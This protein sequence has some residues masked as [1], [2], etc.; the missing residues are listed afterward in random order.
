MTVG[1]MCLTYALYYPATTV[2]TPC[3]STFPDKQFAAALVTAGA[4]GP[5]VVHGST[6]GVRD[7]ALRATNW[8]TFDAA[9]DSVVYNGNLVAAICLGDT[10]VPVGDTQTTLMSAVKPAVPYQAPVISCGNSAVSAS[11]TTTTTATTTTGGVS[12]TMTGATAASTAAAV[13][14]TIAAGSS[15]T[16]VNTANTV[17]GLIATLTVVASVA[18]LL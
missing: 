9:Y 2:L 18:V 7:V 11:T 3:I 6:D 10:G 14:A 17:N 16:N 13:S 8:S 1:E 5:G 15:K 12:A 4:F